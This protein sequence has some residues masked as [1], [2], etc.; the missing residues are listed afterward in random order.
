MVHLAEALRLT[1]EH[2]RICG[3]TFLQ[4]NGTVEFSISYAQLFAAAHATAKW[5]LEQ[6]QPDCVERFACIVFKSMRD[7]VVS[8]WSCIMP[9]LFLYC[10][11]IQLY[12]TCII[13]L[14]YNCIILLLLL[15]RRLLLLL[16]L[17]SLQ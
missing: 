11:C 13:I 4:S 15:R 6:E 8:F 14:Y 1:A 10:N 5:L 2:E 3:I 7:Q 17:L 16:L 12:Y 9:V